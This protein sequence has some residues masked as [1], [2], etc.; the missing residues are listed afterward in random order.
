MSTEQVGGPGPRVAPG[1]QHRAGAEPLGQQGLGQDLAHPG[2]V[3][4]GIG[5][6]H[7]VAGAPVVDQAA[8]P[9]DVGGHHRGAA[10]GRLQGHQAEGLRPARHQA[11]VGRPVV[12]REQLVGRGGTNS[13]LVGQA[14]GASTSRS[15]RRHLLL[16]V[17]AA[18][19]PDDDQ[20][21]VGLVADHRGQGGARPRP[22]PSAA[23][24]ARRR[25]A[26]GP[27][28]AGRGP[29]G[30]GPGRRGRRRRGRP[31]GPRSGC[32]TGRPRRGRRSG[33]PRPSTTPAR[34]P[35]SG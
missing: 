3:G 12:G 35:S 28:P 16:A 5:L 19:A 21:G 31:R 15:M 30:P 25:A 33:R 23:G 11:H 18:R 34:C 1:P 2:G 20:A 13:T 10:G 32:A 7:Q 22:R 27:P 24:S 4:L 14:R 9:A 6:L 8:Q 29:A 17:G 26:A